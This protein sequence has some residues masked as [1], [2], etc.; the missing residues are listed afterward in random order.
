MKQHSLDTV[1]HYMTYVARA[2]MIIPVVVIVTGVALYLMKNIEKARV[3]DA[4]S[5]VS[6]AAP[7]PAEVPAKTKTQ[8]IDLK[9]PTICSFTSPDISTSMKI[10]DNSILVDI[11]RPKSSAKYLLNGDCIYTW[12]NASAGSKVCGVGQYLTLFQ[13]L[14]SAGLVD[15]NTIFSSLETY[16]F[17]KENLPSVDVIS[18]LMESCK[19]GEVVKETFTVPSNIV[20]KNVQK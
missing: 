3:E 17:K 2:T 10:K 19:K 12:E 16:G 4:Q 11:V 14:S 5:V 8:S 9:G 13:T 6:Q 18:G 1:N 15:I 7:A 20:F